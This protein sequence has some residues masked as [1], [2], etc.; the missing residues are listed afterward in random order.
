MKNYVVRV[1]AGKCGQKVG[2][3]L[4]SGSGAGTSTPSLQGA[5]VFNTRMNRRYAYHRWTPEALEQR[6]LEIVWVEL[7]PPPEALH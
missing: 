2:T 6:G 1:I 4:A 7:A 3:Y 5:F